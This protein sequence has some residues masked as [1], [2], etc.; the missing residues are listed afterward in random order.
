MGVIN[1]PQSPLR[2]GGS[3]IGSPPC[4]GGV[5]GGASSA[6]VHCLEKEHDPFF[7]T[8]R[9][10]QTPPGQMDEKHEDGREQSIERRRLSGINP[11]QSPLRKGGSKIVLPLAKGELGVRLVLPLAKGEL[12]GVHLLQSSTAWRKNT[13]RSF[14]PD[15]SIKLHQRK[16]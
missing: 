10:N 4:E 7:S 15:G 2:K 6:I 11:P 8:G 14:P 9:F 13:I 3:K 16:R 12:E 1:P 5:S